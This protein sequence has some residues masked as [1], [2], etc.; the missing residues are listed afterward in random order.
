MS[1]TRPSILVIDDTPV[2]ILALCA[3]LET[4]YEVRFATSGQQGLDLASRYLPDLVLL[5]VMMPEMDGFE[6]C[7]RM[8]TSA[9]LRQVPIM[10]VTAMND[11]EAETTGLELG[12]ADYLTKPINVGVARQRI[13][14]LL[15]REQLRRDLQVQ[16]DHLEAVVQQ[17]TEALS[18]AKDEAEAASRAK[19]AFLANMSH[20]LRT[21]MNAILGLTGI[22]LRHTSDPQMVDSL[23]KVTHASRQL[24]AIINDILDISKIEAD[25]MSLEATD[26]LV[27]EVV[28]GLQSV[29]SHRARAGQLALRF[30]IDPALASLHL[31]GDPM[32]FGQVLSNL[33]A[34][35]LKF[36]QRGQVNVRLRL[37]EQGPEGVVLYCEVQDTGIGIAPQSQQRLFSAFEQADLSTTR[38][39]GGTGLGLTICKR[40]TEMMGGSIGVESQLGQGS[41]FWFTVRF[42]RSTN[43]VPERGAVESAEQ[44]LKASHA[45]RRVLLAEDDVINQEVT[46][47]LLRDLGLVVD[48]VA[49]GSQAVQYARERRYDLILMDVQMPIMDGLEAT[50]QIRQLP[51]PVRVP[52]LA[53]TASALLEDKAD[54]LA[55]GMDDYL[56]KPIEPELLYASLLKWLEKS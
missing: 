33:T 47:W 5:D 38:R 39:Y 1:Q 7:R 44:V 21:P 34:N 30:E 26:F 37:L 3:A 48:T 31:L 55:A 28:E 18:R 15:E 14:N 23:T 56:S 46:T 43:P 16:R 40:L 6:V 52:I 24:L 36:T 45:G 4:E 11:V 54:C 17:R 9:D 27:S 20:E 35:A 19:T 13:R 42:R 2:N 25:H 41:R 53:L 51:G 22:A 29:L 32:R 49:D 10:F 8:K 12:A 50:R